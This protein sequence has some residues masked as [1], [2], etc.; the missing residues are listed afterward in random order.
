MKEKWWLVLEIETEEGEEE[1][2]EKSSV[3]PEDSVETTTLIASDL[4]IEAGA[5]VNVMRLF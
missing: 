1:V 5:S 4:L 3:T 2:K